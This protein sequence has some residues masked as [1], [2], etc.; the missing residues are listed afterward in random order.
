MWSVR[1]SLLLM[2][3]YGRALS[4]C[5]AQ[6]LA[7]LPRVT[8]SLPA[9]LRCGA[10]LPPPGAS[11]LLWPP[12][13]RALPQAPALHPVARTHLVPRPTFLRCPR[14]WTRL[15]QRSLVRGFPWTPSTCSGVFQN[16]FA[17]IKSWVLE[18]DVALPLEWVP[19][20]E[21]WAT[22]TEPL[23]RLLSQDFQRN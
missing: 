10:W 8:G 20:S 16:A 17:Q 12:R 19:T 11:V 18:T 9:G 22:G 21:A 5:L 7:F 14:P 15:W 4:G 2:C 6:P 3:S 1:A 23:T 13:R